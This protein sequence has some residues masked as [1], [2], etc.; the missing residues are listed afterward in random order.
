MVL[1]RGSRYPQ[2]AKYSSPLPMA[3]SQ[4]H[5]HQRWI[6]LWQLRCSQLSSRSISLNFFLCIRATYRKIDCSVLKWVV[7]IG[8]QRNTI[9]PQ[10][11]VSAGHHSSILLGFSWF[12]AGTI[13]PA[14]PLPASHTSH[15]QQCS[16]VFHL[17]IPNHPSLLLPAEQVPPPIIVENPS[18]P[19]QENGNNSH[20]VV[21]SFTT[22]MVPITDGSI[23]YHYGWEWDIS[24][25]SLWCHW[26]F[27]IRQFIGIDLN[28]CILMRLFMMKH[29]QYLL[30]GI[31]KWTTI[32]SSFRAYQKLQ[33]QI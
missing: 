2:R 15:L 18:F 7:S 8:E 21:G 24:L 28:R 20:H 30:V 27:F 33:L 17:R 31:N 26:C 11:N 14:Y 9:A 1:Q 10:R 16:I 6:H 4:D 12:P 25:H 22:I 29:Y 5:Q 19:K 3:R 13:E 32:S 23:G